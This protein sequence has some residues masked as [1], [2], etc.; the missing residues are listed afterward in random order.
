M[1][2]HQERVISEQKELAEK[3]IKLTIFLT[4]LDHVNL[5]DQEEWK[6]LHMQL[7]IMTEY[8]IILVSRIRDFKE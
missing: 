7:E 5:M 2:P 1:L 4:D 3:I 6:R 8:S